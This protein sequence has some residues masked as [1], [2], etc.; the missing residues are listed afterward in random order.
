MSGHSKCAARHPNV[1]QGILMYGKASKDM[2]RHII[3]GY[4]LGE[5]ILM[6]GKASRCMVRHPNV[7]QGIQMCMAAI[8]F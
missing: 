7:W 3:Y 5:G 2:A 8:L 4:N 6:Y 1:C